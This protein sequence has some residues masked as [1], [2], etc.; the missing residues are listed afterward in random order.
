[1][2]TTSR[3]AAAHCARRIAEAMAELRHEIES[4]PEFAGLS[5]DPVVMGLLLVMAGAVMSKPNW[6]SRHELYECY[7]DA[8]WPH[9]VTVRKRIEEILTGVNIRADYWNLN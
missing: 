6:D 2:E 7:G 1:M 8:K 3:D 5:A 4:D 9:S